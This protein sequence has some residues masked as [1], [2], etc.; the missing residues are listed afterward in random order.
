MFFPVR[1][2]TRVRGHL[3]QVSCA[4]VVENHRGKLTVHS[5]C[6][7]SISVKVIQPSEGLTDITPYVMTVPSVSDVLYK[8]VWLKVNSSHSSQRRIS[9]DGENGDAVIYCN[10]SSYDITTLDICV[11]CTTLS[12]AG[13][14]S[15]LTLCGCDNCLMYFG[16]TVHSPILLFAALCCD[17]I[18]IVLLL[19]PLH[20]LYSY[21]IY[22]ETCRNW[23]TM[24]E[25]T[26]ALQD[27]LCLGLMKPTERIS[28]SLICSLGWR[29]SCCVAQREQSGPCWIHPL[30]LWTRLHHTTFRLRERRLE[31]DDDQRQNN[32][33]G[34]KSITAECSCTVLKNR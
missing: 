20:N 14:I 7:L 11:D 27:Q 1:T 17:S 12:V 30:S 6:L 16:W 26:T 19:L 23:P 29:A 5:L 22:S 4:C 10:T 15:S 31:D 8:H 2:E 34:V 18:V 32:R 33:M 9:G 3:P 24:K 21:I 13:V 25:L 28:L